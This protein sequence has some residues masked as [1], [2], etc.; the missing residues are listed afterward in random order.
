MCRD[1]ARKCSGEFAI[2]STFLQSNIAPRIIIVDESKNQSGYSLG[3]CKPTAHRYLFKVSANL[4]T[5]SR[6]EVV[7]LFREALKSLDIL[8]RVEFHQ[9]LLWYK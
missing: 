7:F 2:N 5:K 3:R 9:L 1:V 4:E 6:L 8:K